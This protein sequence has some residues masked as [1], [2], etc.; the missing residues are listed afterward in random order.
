MNPSVDSGSAASQTAPLTEPNDSQ[1]QPSRTSPSTDNTILQPQN[2]ISSRPE[3]QYFD[4][5]E[6]PWLD[7]TGTL[8]S[9]KILLQNANG[10]C[11][12]VAL[13]NT[14]VLSYPAT[15][16]YTSGK[17]RISVKGLL[18]YLG[19]LLLEKVSD[20]ERGETNE[21]IN[22]TDDVL[23][24]LPK[25]VTG[26]NIDPMFDGQFS[27]SPE[28]SLFRLYDVDVVHGWLVDPES[29]I[30]KY[31]IEAESYEQSQMLLVEALEIEANKAKLAKDIGSTKPSKTVPQPIA[32]EVEE[33]LL[34]PDTEITPDSHDNVS[35]P[36]PP[37]PATPVTSSPPD[38][39]ISSKLSTPK[40]EDPSSP[41]SPVLQSP[42][43]RNF[44]EHSLNDTHPPKQDRP[45]AT[46]LFKDKFAEPEKVQ[47][48]SASPVPGSPTP[49]RES[50][51]IS[52][53]S[54]SL[55]EEVK[56]A[57]D[58]ERLD[59]AYAVQLFLDQYPTQLTEY[60]ISFLNELLPPGNMAVFFRN[61][62]F[63]TI[64]KPQS[65]DQPLLMLVTDAGFGG[66]KNIVWQS[67][68]SINGQ[69]D[70][71][72]DG[73][74]QISPLDE[75]Q[76]NQNESSRP[77]MTDDQMVNEALDFEY[78]RQ[79]QEEDDRRLAERTA[80]NSARQQQQQQ[81][82]QR[83]QSST[84]NSRQQASQQSARPT[85]KQQVP[86]DT[87]RTSKDKDKCIIC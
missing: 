76:E 40:L 66:K 5:K 38:P 24:L 43:S 85:P 72:F 27:N 55:P 73:Q 65:S 80:A 39:L 70:N 61:D 68:S 86:V 20:S 84:R 7:R 49:S 77:I 47:R 11:P 21:I 82:Q 26:L 1:T 25:L 10:P 54:Y 71:F 81:Q 67:L 46:K 28:M 31:V 48:L 4:T 87:R 33:P 50:Y 59:K 44:S 22:D 57:E 2:A 19:E 37:N 64:Y 14:M 18:E 75:S 16:A 45:E 35:S 41:I 58:Q 52:A 23:R 34:K 60:G 9:V 30:G 74:F 56:A 69:F 42:L 17:E 63:S 53:K 62:H 13:I 83:P 15:A 3:I 36:S 6:I 32:E 78:A 29:S 8:G 79:L 12:L 51:T